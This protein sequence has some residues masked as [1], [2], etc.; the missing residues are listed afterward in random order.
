MANRVTTVFIASPKIAPF[1]GR[2]VA[3]IKEDEEGRGRYFADN[4]LIDLARRLGDGV[5]EE[6]YMIE[7][8]LNKTGVWHAE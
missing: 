2:Y 6:W 1:T 5:G 3:L 7:N 8:D 4:S